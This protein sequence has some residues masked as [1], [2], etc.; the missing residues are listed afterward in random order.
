MDGNRCA[1]SRDPLLISLLNYE[2][3]VACLVPT[4]CF[5]SDELKFSHSLDGRGHIYVILE[6]G[7]FR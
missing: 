5:L 2:M 6:L 3:L 4:K 7:R 1:S